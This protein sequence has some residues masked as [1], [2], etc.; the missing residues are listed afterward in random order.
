MKLN[1][2]WLLSCL[3]MTG[4]T[5]NALCQ[6][7]PDPL[8][9]V[10][11]PIA[12]REHEQRVQAI[13]QAWL[14]VLAKVSG[15]HP[16]PEL[17]Q[18]PE[19]ARLANE[20]VEQYQYVSRDDLSDH[21]GLKVQFSAAAVDE[22]LQQQRLTP[23]HKRPPI[24]LW[25]VI[26]QG[27]QLQFLHSDVVPELPKILDAMNLDYG[28]PLIVPLYDAQDREAVRPQELLAKVP[29][30]MV[31]AGERYDAWVAIVAVVNQ[32]EGA[33]PHIDWR[34]IKDGEFNGQWSTRDGDRAAQLKSG[35]E[36]LLP[37]IAGYHAP[38]PWIDPPLE[39][40]LTVN[41]VSGFNDYWRLTQGLRALPTVER[42]QL[43]R[44]GDDQTW[45][46]ISVRGTLEALQLDLEA[47]LQL[48]PELASPGSIPGL[49][50]R[51]HP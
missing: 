50:Y 3:V 2:H 45:F 30:T 21:L 47:T 48:I 33:M 18:N 19:L 38:S 41:G 39:T 26:K 15:R 29:K 14:K 1:N 25:G 44:R 37:E 11:V 35:L 13:A 51:L 46:Q 12:G 4:L 7:E 6:A 36:H 5:W 17:I 8:Y 16:P 42:L 27:Q 40:A 34:W 49:H 24:I 10:Q 28:L 43:R 9:E 23:W 31:D 32:M 20:R 22:A